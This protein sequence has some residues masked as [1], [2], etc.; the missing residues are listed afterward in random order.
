MINLA[1]FHLPSSQQHLDG[2][3]RVVF[4]RNCNQIH[5]ARDQS[6]FSSAR[7]HVSDCGTPHTASYIA[8]CVNNE[9]TALLNRL[10]LIIALRDLHICAIQMKPFAPMHLPALQTN[11]QITSRV[12]CNRARAPLADLLQN[13]KKNT[14]ERT[15]NAQLAMIL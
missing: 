3:A 7:F 2:R 8:D 1:P 15:A 14:W 5:R 10:P 11:R 6:L 12:S 9:T 13:A 4:W